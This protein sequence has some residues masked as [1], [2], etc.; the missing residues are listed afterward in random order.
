MRFVSRALQIRTVRPRIQTNG[1][2][3]TVISCAAV[4][5]RDPARV[6][7]Y[8]IRNDETPGHSFC[9][10]VEMDFSSFLEDR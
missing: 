3:T 10:Y 7:T 4:S 2:T 5:S 1:A 9:E 6:A 8:V